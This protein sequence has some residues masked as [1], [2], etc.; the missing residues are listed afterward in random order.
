MAREHDRDAT[1]GGNI[2]AAGKHLSAL[3]SR[4]LGGGM[5]E[6][7]SAWG[8]NNSALCRRRRDGLRAKRRSRAVSER[9]EGTALKI[10]LRATPGED[11][12]DRVWEVCCT[13]SRKPWRR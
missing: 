4:S 11:T 5:A 7:S 8:C 1:R 2:A 12:T 13:E 6:E 9:S 10:W 3:C